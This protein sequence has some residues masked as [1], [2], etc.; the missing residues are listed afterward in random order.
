MSAL[1][2]ERLI[3]IRKDLKLS[4]E[5]VAKQLGISRTAMTQI[6]AGN[7]KIS[8]K[9]LEMLS[10]IYGVSMDIIMNGEENA[11]VVVFARAFN[12]LTEQDQ[13]EVM[14]LIQFKKRL[15]KELVSNAK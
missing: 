5:Y 4:Q 12:N 11:N 6:E 13:E 10:N 15:K 7:R 8:A 1:Y 14:N 2:C 9:E 3:K